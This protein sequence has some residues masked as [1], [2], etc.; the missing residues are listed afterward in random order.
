MQKYNLQNSQQKT[1]KL[2]VKLHD[3][4]L[5]CFTYVPS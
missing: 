4:V 2:I 1:F 3:L 5:A